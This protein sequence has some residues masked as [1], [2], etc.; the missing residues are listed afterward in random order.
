MRQ[1]SDAGWM[2]PVC[3]HRRARPAFRVRP[4][5]IVDLDA[6]ELAPAASAFGATVGE[7]V[8]C[9]ACRHGSL[10][11]APT[12]GELVAAYAHVED[13]RS[14]EEEPGQVATARRDLVEIRDHLGT[15]PGRLLD[16]GCW[17]GSLLDAAGELG[18]TT[19][20]IEPSTWAA[21]QAASRGLDVSVGVIEDIALPP[22]SV[23]VIA[24]C[25]VLE[26]LHDPAAAV[27]HI[28]ELLEPG[29]VL[30]ATVPDAGSVLARVLGHRWWSVLPMHLQYF[31]RGS[32]VTLLR[33]AGFEIAALH[34]HP[35]V[36][37]YA[38]YGDRL[39]EFLPG[40]GPSIA[41][42]IRRT[43]L[44]QR[45]FGPDLRDRLAVVARRPV[46]GGA[47]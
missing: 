35:K 1:G 30:L 15:A 36:F 12:P 38:Y 22:S 7:V 5:A 21:R 32:L 24:C 3:A 40:L 27:R 25:D 31:T 29:G 34:T 37:T 39:G 26:H 8:R 19:T 10:H 14:L 45:P 18:W 46:H 47:P 44:A 4:S 13:P 2:C 20:G 43:P 23:Q 42:L 16:I 17:T 41:S 28:G 6:A 11:G 9:A 33:S